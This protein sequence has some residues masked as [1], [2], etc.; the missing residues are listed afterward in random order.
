MSHF[1]TAP[2][3]FRRHIPQGSG[4]T[5]ESFR[6]AFQL[7][8]ATEL[9]VTDS[10]KAMLA[11]LVSRMDVT[12]QTLALELVLKAAYPHTFLQLARRAP[13]APISFDAFKSG[14]QMAFAQE[15]SFNAN[16]IQALAHAFRRLPFDAKKSALSF[17]QERNY[18]E[19]YQAC[20]DRAP[21]VPTTVDSF[22]RAVDMASATELK[23][24]HA[25]R[26]QLVDSFGRLDFAGQSQALEY[27]LGRNLTDTY[28]A[29]AQTSQVARMSLK[30]FVD[31]LSMASATE[32]K[33]T[34]SELDTL[35]D[36]FRR[37][38]F[39]DQAQALEQLAKRNLPDVYAACAQ[40]RW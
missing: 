15:L 34:A 20:A 16:E 12:G 39:S 4:V 5:F 27:L 9:K 11:D 38:S 33:V 40:A 31:G 18:T 28:A 26:E 30:G 10:E 25:E 24:T 19:L 3:S 17:M 6:Q 2:I 1:H 36:A 37:L 13:Y 7:A 14:V 21:F 35:V 29:A 23:V 32:L 22:K 8:A